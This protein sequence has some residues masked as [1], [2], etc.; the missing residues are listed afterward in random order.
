[1]DRSSQGS[2]VRVIFFFHRN[3]RPTGWRRVASNACIKARDVDDVKYE[4][5]NEITGIIIIYLIKIPLKI[6]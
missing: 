6:V 5:K 2:C 4:E 1:M 3:A